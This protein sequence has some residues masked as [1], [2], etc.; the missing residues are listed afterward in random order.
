MPD[1][2]LND[3]SHRRYNPLT[4]SWLLVSPHR[5]KRPW[6]GQ[7]EDPYKHTLPA[8]DPQCYLCPGNKRAQGDVNP[9]YEDTFVFVN[10]YSAVK[11]TQAEYL[12][13]AAQA[14][15]SSTPEKRREEKDL[16]A[17]LLR[18]EAATGK[19][20]VVTFAPKHNVTLADMSAREIMPVIQMWTYVFATHLDPQSPVYAAGKQ[21][22]ADH[23]ALSARVTFGKPAHQLRYMQIFENKG[24]AMGCS[25]P[26]PH[27]QIWTT[28]SLPEEPGKE[29]AQM[30]RYRR[31]HGSHR[32]LLGDYIKLEQLKQ[33]RIVYENDTFLVVCPWWA[34]WPFEVM[35]LSKRHVR[36]IVELTDTE[37][38][39]FAEAIQEV[40]RRYDNLF[41]TSFP[42]SSG[43]HQAPLC[44]ESEDEADSSWFH[45]HFYPPL[46]RS[47][48]VRKFLVGFELLGEPQRD[49]TPEQAAS[50]LRDCGHELYRKRTADKEANGVD[51]MRA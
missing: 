49:I 40:T 41:E 37:R 36:A 22:L 2:I 10:D 24:A 13:A 47:A 7:Q 8:Y 38:H 33:E 15:G 31:E 14:D 34:I 35:L 1:E 11:E 25:N 30:R 32:H 46:L 39:D 50:R 43:I 29:L 4:N 28:S 5:S 51:T 12:P 42:Y 20:Y 45:M 16:E 26:H 18:A 6:Q 19:C 23:P 48:T 9:N 27:C 3:I 17:L 21:F 44:C